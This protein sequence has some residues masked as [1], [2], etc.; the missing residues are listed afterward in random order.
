MQRKNKRCYLI[1]SIPAHGHTNPLLVIAQ[2]LVKRGHKVYFYST[3]EFEGKIKNSGAL[4]LAYPDVTPIDLRFAKYGVFLARRLI[5]LADEFIEKIAISENIDCIIHDSIAPWGKV[6]ALRNTISAVSVSTTLILTKKVLFNYVSFNKLLILDFLKNGIGAYMSY[7]KFLKKHNMH[8]IGFDEIF[9][10]REK[11]NLILTAKIF[12]PESPSFDESFFFVGPQISSRI[13]KDT[14][15]TTLKNVKEYIYISL[16]TI[17]NNDIDF[18]NTCISALGNT[19]YTI[20][21]AIGNHFTHR[22]LENIPSNFIIRAHLPQLDILK[23][24]KLF[25]T[26]AGMN[27]IM[28][29]LY[30]G[31][32]MVMVPQMTEQYINARRIH[33]LGAGIVIDKKNLTKESLRFAVNK[34]LHTS[35][36]KEEVEK[37]RK[38]LHDAGGY[39][40]TVDILETYPFTK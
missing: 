27:S 29:S 19:T 8:Y 9:L 23:K 28:E 12:Q 35:S 25:I 1:F 2:E 38:E 20:L 10:N 6:I 14:L 39:K 30:Y 37:L 17:H 4:F 5:A 40:R 11:V 18:F 36:Y 7:R 3:K 31:V 33:E 22:D 15:V 24:A 13:D 26:H 16:G 32:P 21:L 34:I